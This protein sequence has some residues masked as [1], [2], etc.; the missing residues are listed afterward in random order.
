MLITSKMLEELVQIPIQLHDGL[1]LMLDRIEKLLSDRDPKALLRITFI[2]SMGTGKTTIIQSIQKTLEKQYDLVHAYTNSKNLLMT[3]LKLMNSPKPVFL[4]NDDPDY[5]FFKKFKLR[6]STAISQ[7]RHSLKTKIIFVQVAHGLKLLP[8]LLRDSEIKV[9]TST[10]N[11]NYENEIIEK[12]LGSTFKEIL[13]KITY[14]KK[15]ERI[16][17]L[18]GLAIIKEVSQKPKIVY[19]RKVDD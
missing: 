16:Y 12:D 3:L 4:I 17:E 19:F 13:D 10:F 6:V 11:N 1:E 15:I 9:Y 18:R 7:I 8:P 5:E 2:G 14:I